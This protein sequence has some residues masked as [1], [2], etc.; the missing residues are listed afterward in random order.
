MNTNNLNNKLSDDWYDSNTLVYLYGTFTSGGH[1]S[2]MKEKLDA[3]NIKW[4]VKKKDF[5]KSTH[6]ITTKYFASWHTEDA[7]FINHFR[8]NIFTP[9]EV[10]RMIKNIDAGELSEYSEQIL[11]LLKTRDDN[12]I[13]LACTLINDNVI[14]EDWLP[15][16]LINKENEDVRNLLDKNDINKGQWYVWKTEEMFCSLTRELTRRLQ[17]SEE[18]IKQFLYDFYDVRRKEY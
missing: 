16:L 6:L 5:D 14:E 8:K 11:T 9:R 2:E 1:K 17:L 18:N 7:V 13:S 10:N 15:W 3:L 4:T 12:N